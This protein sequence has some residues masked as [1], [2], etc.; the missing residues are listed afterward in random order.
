MREA[1]S[2]L[3][4]VAA[5]CLVAGCLACGRSPAA[6]LEVEPRVVRLDP[7]RSV[8]LRVEFRPESAIDVPP[9][10]V[11]VFAHLLD[12]RGAV[13]RTFDHPLPAGWKKGEILAYDLDLYESVQADPLAA[14]SYA[15]T[16]GLYDIERGYRWPLRVEGEKGKTREYRVATVEA[17]PP[18]ADNPR[19]QFAGDW[20]PP[21]PYADKQ[22]IVL[23]WMLGAAEIRV[24]EIP[25]PGTVRLRLRV[26]GEPGVTLRSTCEP[27]SVR[28]LPKGSHWISIE[29]AGDCEI[30]VDP[31]APSEHAVAALARLEVVA[32]RPK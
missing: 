9:E 8:P 4:R 12:E 7:G 10:R 27:G 30:Q 2:T 24:R 22:T 25:S 16:M 28:P 19:F 14:G 32:W 26:E 1:T 18:G 3:L 6:S 17:A 13:V 5:A 31:A 21:E 29:A 15:L 20:S 11:Y 23:R